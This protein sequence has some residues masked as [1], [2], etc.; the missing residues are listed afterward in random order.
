[1]ATKGQLECSNT[2]DI[3]PAEVTCTIR[4]NC[5]L[6]LIT[7]VKDNGLFAFSLPAHIPCKQDMISLR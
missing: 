7:I 2:G 1:M 3:R 6:V 5:N 4:K